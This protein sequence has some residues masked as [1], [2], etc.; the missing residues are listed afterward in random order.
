MEASQ[1]SD[2]PIF[3]L[4]DGQVDANISS[5]GSAS[6]SRRRTIMALRGS[7]LVVAV[8]KELRITSLADTASSSNSG[9]AYKVNDTTFRNDNAK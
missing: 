8:G 7:D 6:G 2:H 9:K 3:S 4:H 1:L 5:G